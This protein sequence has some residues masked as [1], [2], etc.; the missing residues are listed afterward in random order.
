MT[1]TAVPKPGQRAPLTRQ[2]IVRSAVSYIDTHGLGGLSMHKLGAELGVKAMSLYKYVAS[3]DDLLDGVVE[4]L[5][6]EV[7]SAAPAT[8]DW[9]EGYRSVANALRETVHRHPNAAFLITSHG[10]MPAQA[11]RCIQAHVTAATGSG[12]PEAHAYAWLRTITSYALGTAFNEVAWGFGQHG[13]RPNTV[14]ELLRPDVP[15]ELA[16]VAEVFCG[17]CN[18]DA[19]FEMGL[20][21]MLRGIDTPPP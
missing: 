7:E 14:A 4:Q 15:P 5:W 9:R 12:V 1:T 8:G 13:C 11:L 19:Q 16:E 17:Q 18:P 20:C 2:R 6:V 3:K 10:I 21:L